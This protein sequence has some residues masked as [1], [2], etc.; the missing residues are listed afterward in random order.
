[1]RVFLPPPIS[2][3]QIIIPCNGIVVISTNKSAI[4]FFMNEDNKVSLLQLVYKGLGD[5]K[6]A[7]IAALSR[8]RSY[9][10]GHLLCREG[11]NEDML[12]II[13]EGKVS[14]SQQTDDEEGE[15]ILRIGGK[16]D[17]VGEMG[18]IQNAPRA[19]SVRTTTSCT[20]LEMDKKDFETIL[21]KNPRIAIDLIRITIDR[22]RENDQRAISDLQKTNKVLR[23]M[24][25]NKMEFIQVTA[26]ELRTPLTVL[27]GYVNVLQALLDV[28]AK[29]SLKEVLEGINKGADRMHTIVNTMLDLTRI[30]AETLKVSLSPVPVKQILEKA[31]YKL[32]PEAKERAIELVVQYYADTPNIKA[33]P[34][35]IE[36]AIYHLLVN[37]IKYTPDGGEIHISACPSMFENKVKSA[38]ISIRDTGIGLDAEHH[39]LVFEKFYQVAGVANHS[40]GKTTFKGGG[41]GLGL[42]IVHG[43]AEAHGGK[44]WVESAGCDEEHCLGSTFYL[45]IPAS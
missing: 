11:A 13:A 6:L 32:A 37:A 22:L 20:T 19:A 31:V 29:A 14:I 41:S 23:Q 45:E 7:E 4:L 36:K 1:M 17:M 44:T 34:A 26:H 10:A 25:R 30:D 2:N 43:I 9:P 24:D 35:L 16:G 12:Y 40:S 33:D 15:R 39:Q 5:E 42:A 28:Q 27:K 8:I 18:L 3:D 38:K 21:S